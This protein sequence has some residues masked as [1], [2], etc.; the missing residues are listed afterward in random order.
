M[1]TLTNFQAQPG[2]STPAAATPTVADPA[3]LGLAA[4]ALTTFVLS[5]VN[6]GLVPKGVEPVVFGIAAAYGG[7]AQLCA[8]MWEFQRKNTFG[9]T[10]FSSYGAFWI[11]FALL[12]TL[13]IGK[14][15]PENIPTAVGL[16]LLAW[17]I[18]TTYMTIEARKHA[19]PV[20][21]TFCVLTPTFYLLAFGA[22]FSMPAL[23]QFGGYLGLVT[24]F[25]AWYA[26][27]AALSKAG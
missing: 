9:A 8:G 26:S 21:V 3:P 15:P 25:A 20:F 24:A 12:V 4:F 13:Y 1:A 14:I 7:I 10:A 6:A 19:M 2:L 17:S 16:F 22:L 23:S 11:S 5:S 27:Y 18:F